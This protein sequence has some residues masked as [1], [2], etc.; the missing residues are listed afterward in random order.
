[1]GVELIQSFMMKTLDGRIFDRATHPFY[2]TVGPQVHGLN[3]AL[4]EATLVAKL[5]K[6]VADQ[7]QTLCRFLNYTPLSVNNCTLYGIWGS[8]HRKN[9]T[10]AT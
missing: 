5:S 7:M 10:A 8:T 9:L 4:L 3:R 1:M 2:L 6:W